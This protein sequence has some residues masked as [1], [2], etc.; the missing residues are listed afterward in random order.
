MNRLS[1]SGDQFAATMVVDGAGIDLLADA[2][3][4]RAQEN[5]WLI[6]EKVWKSM[7]FF[8]AS[9]LLDAKLFDLRTLNGG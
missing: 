4:L 1:Q 6:L 5:L 3:F 7:V 2:S 9:S 8:V